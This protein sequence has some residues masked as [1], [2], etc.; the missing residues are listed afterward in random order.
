MSSDAHIQRNPNQYLVIGHR[1]HTLT[2]SQQGM[3]EPGQAVTQTLKAEF[4]EEALAKINVTPEERQ[5]IAKQIERLFQK[6]DEV[7][8]HDLT[9]L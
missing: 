3:V 2:L 6:G 1:L 5:K 8:N 7:W 4:G 9:I